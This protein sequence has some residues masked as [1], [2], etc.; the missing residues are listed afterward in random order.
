MHRTCDDCRLQ[1]GVLL[2]LLVYIYAILG[3]ELFADVAHGDFL[4]ANGKLHDAARGKNDS[5]RDNG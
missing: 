5:Y 2:S 1:V 4:D 3:V